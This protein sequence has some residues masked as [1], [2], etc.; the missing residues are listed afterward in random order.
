M[1]RIGA[2]FVNTTPL[3][4][5]GNQAQIRR[6]LDLARA[7]GTAMLCLPELCVTGYGCEDRFL[8]PDLRLRAL[9]SLESLLPDTKGL[10]VAL[11]LPFEF[12]GILYNCAVLCADGRLVGIIPKQNL[13]KS[14][15]HYEP[16]WFSPWKK[17]RRER[18]PL[19]GSEVALGDWIFQCGEAMLGFEICEDAWVMDRPCLRL[20][21]RGANLI[22]APAAS[23]FA[24]G[25]RPLREGLLRKAGMAYAYANLMGNEAGRAIYDGGAMVGDPF[26]A[27]AHGARFSFQGAGLVSADMD[28]R[29]VHVG[30]GVESV[31]MPLETPAPTV[32]LKN[33]GV[34][35]HQDEYEEFTRAAA[36]G[37]FDYGRKSRARGFTLSLSG[38]ADSSACAALVYAMQKL[39]AAEG[40]DLP[41]DAPVLRCVYQSTANSSRVTRDAAH[42]VAQAVGAAFHEFDL[43]A[44]VSQYRQLAEIALGRT[45][46]WESDDTTLQNLQARAR[47]PG[48]W[49]LANA[50]GTLLL[51]TNNRSEA[52]T[53]YTSMDGDTSGGLAPLAG[54]GKHFLRAWL[55][56]F[57]KE[58]PQGVG[59]LPAL[60]AVNVQ[61]PTAEL[62]PLETKQRDE[63]DLMPYAVLDQIESL[64]TKERLAPIE[65]FEAMKKDF[66]AEQVPQLGRWIIRFFE[67]WSASQW[68]RERLAPSFHLDN[69]NVDPRTWCRFPILSGGFKAEIEGLKGLLS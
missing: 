10:V 22:F 57:E 67:L 29:T 11:G 24:L 50:T 7:Q 51:A 14:G 46:S 36:L 44:L 12:D 38:G 21:S 35:Q 2:A 59:I 45:L 52:A 48:L 23:H 27:V 17:G 18:V 69:H 28:L 56:W 31:R 40:I 49:A 66:P 53:G 9:A 1:I 43:E 65:V 63:A 26:G 20:K 47:N 5:E 15:I 37:L 8:S 25:K 34:A 4:W 41:F 68:K 19:F 3:D 32:V 64:A 13:A 16:R 33:S 39:A 58:G 60:H 6:A 55:R 30:E 62:R 42:D 61:E 54:I